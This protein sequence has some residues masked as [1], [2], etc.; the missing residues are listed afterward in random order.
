MHGVVGQLDTSTCYCHGA[1]LCPSTR[2]L[3]Q[4]GLQFQV[5]ILCRRCTTGVKLNVTQQEEKPVPVLLGF[6][7]ILKSLDHK[8]QYSL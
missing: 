7:N 8:S 2:Q 3:S 5:W 6:E 4:C 1:H